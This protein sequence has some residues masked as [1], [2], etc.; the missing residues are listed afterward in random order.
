MDLSHLSLCQG[1]ELIRANE[2]FTK[3]TEVVQVFKQLNNAVIY[4]EETVPPQVCDTPEAD[5]ECH[6]KFLSFW[7]L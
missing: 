4:L 1:T 2:D 5:R 6:T 7:K 3:K